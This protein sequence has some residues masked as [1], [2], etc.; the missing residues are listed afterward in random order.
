MC[1]FLDLLSSTSMLGF[2]SLYIYSV[3]CQNAYV[4]G[5]F[6]IFQIITHFLF[7]SSS[8]LFHFFIIQST[9][10]INKLE[11]VGMHPY[12]TPFSIIIAES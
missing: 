3:R 2:F 6:K 10:M 1:Y 7:Y 11:I 8:V 12:H 9:V 4:I 5:K